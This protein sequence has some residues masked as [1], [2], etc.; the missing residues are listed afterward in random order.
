MKTNHIRKLEYILAAKDGFLTV[1]L[2]GPLSEEN[3]PV[4]DRCLDEI[5][6][7]DT[8]CCVLQFRDV[9]ELN[10]SVIPRLIRVQ[11]RIR[12]KVGTL[13]ICSLKPAFQEWLEQEKAV[14][15]E[16][17]VPNLLDAWLEFTSKQ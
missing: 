8:K 1:I 14:R 5:E 2:L 12:E 11:E 17:L 16:E 9:I 4:L 15:S 10:R 7:R 6:N 3:L 13:R